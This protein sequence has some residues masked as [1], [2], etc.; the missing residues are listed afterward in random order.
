MVAII[1]SS[2]NERPFGDNKQ[3]LERNI[4]NRV[5]QIMNAIWEEAEQLAIFTNLV[6]FE[7]LTELGS[8]GKKLQLGFSKCKT[9]T[10]LR[11]QTDYNLLYCIYS[12]TP[13]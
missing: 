11:H 13:L 1:E 12:G 7:E 9:P 8:V 3:T 6:E 4:E 10:E 2:P 5:Q